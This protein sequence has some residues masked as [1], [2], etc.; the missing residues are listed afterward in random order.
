[1]KMAQTSDDELLDW[2]DDMDEEELRQVL[3]YLILLNADAVQKAMSYVRRGRR[4][5]SGESS[6]LSTSSEH[7]YRSSPKQLSSHRRSRS[8]D[9][10][11]VSMDSVLVPGQS[12]MATPKQS[13]APETT[14]PRRSK[15]SQM[16]VAPKSWEEP[17][18]ISPTRDQPN[19][20]LLVLCTSKPTSRKQGEDQDKAM[21][22]CK[23]AGILPYIVL[24]ESR[25]REA[26]E[27]IRVSKTS[28]FPQ[29]FLRDE[30]TTIFLGDFDTVHQSYVQ[31][32]FNPDIL[33]PTRTTLELS[34]PLL[35]EEK[36]EA[37]TGS[38]SSNRRIDT[39]FQ[40]GVYEE[41]SD[42]ENDSTNVAISPDHLKGIDHLKNSDSAKSMDNKEQLVS[43]ISPSPEKPLLESA[44]RTS[45]RPNRD[46][47]LL[48]GDHLEGLNQPKD[49]DDAKSIDSNELFDP[50]SP[51][52]PDKPLLEAAQ[53]ASEQIKRQAELA[54]GV[55]VY[56]A[57]LNQP[58]VDNDAVSLGDDPRTI[59]D[60]PKPPPPQN[61]LLDA[62][63][64]AVVQREQ[65]IMATVAP[66]V[67]DG[68]DS[69][70]G[71]ATH[72]NIGF[73]QEKITLKPVGTRRPSGHLGESETSETRPPPSPSAAKTKVVAPQTPSLSS[74]GNKLPPIYMAKDPLTSTVLIPSISPSSDRPAW[75]KILAEQEQVEQ[76][77]VEAASDIPAWM[78]NASSSTSI[79]P[80]PDLIAAPSLLNPEST[81]TSTSSASE[82]HATSS[83][84]LPGPTSS[85]Q[86]H[87]TVVSMPPT[88]TESPTTSSTNSID[89]QRG[90]ERKRSAERKYPE[91]GACYLVYDAVLGELNIY[92]SE[93]PI[94]GAVGVWTSH[95]I[96]AFK[97]AQGLG[98]SELI[99]NCASGVQDRQQYYNGWCQFVKAAKSMDA[100]ITILEVGVP[101]DF[102]LYLNGKT[103][104]VQ[105]GSFET[106]P[107][108]A[109]A[110]V[111]RNADFPTDVK[112]KKWSKA[113]KKIGAV[114]VFRSLSARDG[115]S[116]TGSSVQST[117]VR[118]SSL[119]HLEAT[120]TIPEEEEIT[121]DA[122]VHPMMT[123]APVPSAP[124][125]CSPLPQGADLVASS[126][127]SPQE[128]LRSKPTTGIPES[129]KGGYV[130]AVAAP[131]PPGGGCY[132]VYEP[133]SSGR[134]VEH[135]S[136]TP[137][138]D[139]I[140]RW[141]PSGSKSIAGFK[142][143]Q[144][145]G[146]N[147]LIGNCSAG[148]QGR[149]NYSSGWC[150]FVRSAR[151]M[152]ADVMLWDPVGKGLM[153]DVYLYQ[154]DNRPTHQTVKLLPGV[155]QSVEKTLAVTCIPK[156]TPFYEGMAVDI[157]K[158]LADGSNYGASSRF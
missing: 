73:S 99:G 155:G 5:R 22:V 158:W 115:S 65:E 134:L 133:D 143:K 14:S 61:P 79:T 1:M 92:Y 46:Q 149:R 30:D 71:A 43:P 2:I 52:P 75:M 102:F 41:S 106:G 113:A 153:V 28:E 125:V 103:V 8:E 137:L 31:G 6:V 151:V 156:N 64:K 53:K 85:V 49:V 119:S 15:E 39:L 54:R 13:P 147:V 96:E 58:H 19:K 62:A 89:P 112:G 17:T 27:L 48:R 154:D 80:T 104:R 138:E 68:S 44:Q 34:P 148:V 122:V 145:L 40:Q 114:A 142:F 101:V 77:R 56:L 67:K 128:S 18:I 74:P 37:A 94:V 38:S 88:T 23:Q 105:S 50:P 130:S 51:P 57:G 100:T 124:L 29:F 97:Q 33:K 139:A 126:V 86:P 95:D 36:P 116:S 83:P 136:K 10:D 47:P 107:V 82:Q 140:G 150:Q 26:H 55:P 131:N 91:G 63:R 132:L 66:T 141:V 42:D 93:I 78:A 90:I 60:P 45:Q 120:P 98:K 108:D 135:Y 146:R 20:S 25:P 7:L 117:L 111:P 59:F 24:Q 109:V 118:V 32:R 123:T 76:T 144:N 127:E 11:D 110:C 12:E 21:V 157:L 69:T 9:S 87:A 121:E 72:R 81:T 129:P 35:E 16:R 84:L 70:E 152:E 4:K 3:K